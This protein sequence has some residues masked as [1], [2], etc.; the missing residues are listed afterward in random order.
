MTDLFNQWVSIHAV[1]S[2]VRYHYGDAEAERLH[3]IVREHAAP[4]INA[5]IE[6]TKDFKNGDGTVVYRSVGVGMTSIYG[7]PIAMGVREGDVNGVA[8]W[9]SLY[10]GVFN[11]LGYPI[12]HIM[13]ESDGARFVE[14]LGM[15]KPPIKKPKGEKS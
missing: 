2:N 5:T 13:N 14:L 3:E 4:L 6:K 11:C 1:I 12:P 7:V 8:L 9:C 10:N 15:A